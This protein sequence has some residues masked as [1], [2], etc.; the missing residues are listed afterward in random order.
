MLGKGII[1]WKHCHIRK[2]H[3]FFKG[4]S[5]WEKTSFPQRIFQSWKDKIYLKHFCQVGKD[6]LCSKD[7]CVRKRCHFIKEFLCQEK[8]SFSLNILAAH[9]GKMSL[10]HF[11]ARK[12]LSSGKEFLCMPPKSP[13]RNQISSCSYM[14]GTSPHAM[15]KEVN[16]S[17]YGIVG[18]WRSQLICRLWWALLPVPRNILFIWW[19]MIVKS[20][21]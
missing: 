13:K 6:I 5:R 12:G 19:R 17:R 14:Q 8:T 3:P 16:W 15:W 4:F 7:F 20:M 11:P 1:F 2:R 9:K 21:I 10:Y 18:S